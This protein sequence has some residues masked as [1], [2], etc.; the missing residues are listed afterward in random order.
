MC[1]FQSGWL[2]VEQFNTRFQYKVFKGE[3]S[4][5]S[6]NMQGNWIESENT[7]SKTVKIAAL[8]TV[9]STVLNN[10]LQCEHTVQSTNDTH[11]TSI[12][13][14]EQDLWHRITCS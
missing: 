14:L 12:L 2:L 1:H 3:V 7:D 13:H 10:S 9:T 6:H 11:S 8:F 4:R 5:V